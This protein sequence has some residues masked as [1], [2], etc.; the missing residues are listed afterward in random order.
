M[1]K[2][3]ESDMLRFHMAACL[4]VSMIGA[5]PAR[6][7]PSISP[8]TPPTTS[9]ASPD[10]SAPKPNETS[11]QFITE[12]SSN[13]WRASKLVGLNVYGAEDKKIGAIGEVLLDKDG[14]A[15][16]VVIGVGGFLG[17]GQ[18]DVA[19]QFK[20]LE[21]KTEPMSG[22]V[23]TATIPNGVTTPVL[24]LPGTTAPGAGTGTAQRDSAT[25]AATRSYPDHAV[26]RMTKADLQ[27]A[28][29]FH[30]AS[31]T[32]EAPTRQ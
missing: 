3:E 17:I 19:V 22:S 26:L 32:R 30:Y 18:K 2:T 4:A 27:K 8:A 21:W 5:I 15:E 24:P 16:A 1:L 11:A 23:P 9:A 29:T 31:E 7:Q 6:A 12:P 14:R 20:R 25:A 13:Y 28:P 10:A